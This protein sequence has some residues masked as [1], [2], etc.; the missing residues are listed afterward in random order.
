MHDACCAGVPVFLANMAFAAWIKFAL[1]PGAA[2]LM[3]AILALAL[4]Y[5]VFVHARWVHHVGSQ[6]TVQLLDKG[7]RL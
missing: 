5:L 7:V 4:L 2:A 1:F 3:T 6:S